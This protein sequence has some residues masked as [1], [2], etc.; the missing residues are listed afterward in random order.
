MPTSAE[1]AKAL[2][3]AQTKTTPMLKCARTVDPGV[4]RKDGAWNSPNFGNYGTIIYLFR[5]GSKLTTFGRGR[6]HKIEVS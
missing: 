6:S 4:M 1:T 2:F 5:D 3:E